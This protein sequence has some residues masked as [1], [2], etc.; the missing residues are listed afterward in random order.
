MYIRGDLEFPL[1]CLAGSTR[2]SSHVG[3][4]F[5]SILEIMFMRMVDD[6]KIW[7]NL[8]PRY[9]G[10]LSRWHA[11]PSNPGCW[12]L[13]QICKVCQS[14]TLSASNGP[15]SIHHFADVLSQI[16]YSSMVDTGAHG[17]PGRWGRQGDAWGWCCVLSQQ[18]NLTMLLIVNGF[19]IA[20][21]LSP[22][23]SLPLELLIWF[24]EVDRVLTVYEWASIW[25]SYI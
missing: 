6:Y 25:V 24:W 16:I 19:Q 9:M 11:S 3:V 14:T 18:L 15:H 1:H 22:W 8:R 2:S 12:Y 21:S 4:H 23:I 20:P 13:L 5:L 7:H 17:S 10:K